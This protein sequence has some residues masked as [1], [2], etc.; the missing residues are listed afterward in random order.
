MSTAN[1]EHLS[2]A[3]I[4]CFAF[5]TLGALAPKQLGVARRVPNCVGCHKG[6]FPPPQGKGIKI[7]EG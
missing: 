3:E 4:V 5:V 1:F 7:V 2:L 6:R